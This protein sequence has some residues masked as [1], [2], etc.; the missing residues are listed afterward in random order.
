MDRV[1]IGVNRFVAALDSQPLATPPVWCMRQAGRYQRS[2]QALRQRHSFDELCRTPDLAARVA[3]NALEE[4]EFDAAILFSDLLYPLDALGLPVQYGEGGPMLPRRLDSTTVGSLAPVDEAMAR[5][6]FQ[7]QAVALT[8]AQVPSDRG[9]I[10]FIGAPWTLFVYAVEGT[11]TGP[12]ATSKTA[13]PLYRRFADRLVPLLERAARAQIDAGA[14]L[15][16]V[17]D[18]A[19]GDVS[20]STFRTHLAPDLI[21]LSTALPERLGYFARGL[22]PAHLGADGHERLGPWAG[23]GIDWRWDLEDVLTNESRA[24][25]LQG[26]LDPACLHQSGLALTRAIDEFLDPIVALDPEERRGWI[27]SLGHGILQGTP[28]SSV[29]TFVTRVRQRLS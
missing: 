19:A 9:V 1:E 4:F 18:T 8:R 11:H 24:G 16:M 29:R 20:P 7:A 13:L 26:N 25:F 10:G 27:C 3:L 22:H 6:S 28:E 15:V 12:L 14:D 21:R 2:Y 5:L 17:F 23:L